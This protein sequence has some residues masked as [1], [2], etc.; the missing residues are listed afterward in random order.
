MDN[1]VDNVDNND[2]NGKLLRCC[3]GC[4]HWHLVMSPDE[5]YYK[6]PSCGAESYTENWIKSH[7]EHKDY[8]AYLKWKEEHSDA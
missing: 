4:N 7:P 3:P 2:Q 6:C 5:E 8:P 1:I